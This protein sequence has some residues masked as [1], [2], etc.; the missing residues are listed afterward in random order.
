MRFA[1]THREE[2][3]C[4]PSFRHAVQQMCASIGVDLLT[5]GPGDLARGWWSE[6]LG[7][8]DWHL[9]LGVQIVDIQHSRSER[10]SQRNVRAHSITRRTKRSIQHHG[11]RYN[12]KCQDSP[13]LE[14]DRTKYKTRERRKEGEKKKKKR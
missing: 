4:N 10:W 2:I 13:A 5:G 1:S 7:L 14:P 3:K 12:E 9:E 11:R 8:G 6:L